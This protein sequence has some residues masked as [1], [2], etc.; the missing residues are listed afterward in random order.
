MTGMRIRELVTETCAALREVEDRGWDDARLGELELVRD[1]LCGLALQTADQE[2]ADAACG[3]VSEVDG[4]LASAI[5]PLAG[6]RAA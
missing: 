3:V 4:L 5:D 1:V 2:A 6:R